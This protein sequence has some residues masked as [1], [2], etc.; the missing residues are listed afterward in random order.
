MST[1][2]KDY[3]SILGVSPSATDSEIKKAY[4]ALVTKWHPD[5]NNNSSESNT[6][7]AEL[8]E[9]YKVLGD[10]KLRS[11]YDSSRWYGSESFDPNFEWDDSILSYMDFTGEKIKSKHQNPIDGKDL[12]T[13]INI[14]FDEAYSGC[15]KVIK[16]QRKVKCAACNGT[17]KAQVMECAECKGTGVKQS[18]L[19]TRVNIPPG[20]FGEK[21]LVVRGKGDEGL[22]GGNNGNLNITVTVE[23]DKFFKVKDGNLHC[24]VHVSFGTACLGGEIDVRTK[25]GISSL[26]VPEGTQSGTI[27]RLK[28]K[29]LPMPNGA[30]YGDLFVE[31]IVDVPKHLTLE[32]RQAMLSIKDI[33]SW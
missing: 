29:G 2:I 27:L 15:I 33:M 10:A 1:G 28:G 26:Y 12:F 32:Q 21:S 25:L 30:S 16:T 3:Y 14:S 6:K 20:T 4:H 23:E 24:S 19:S 11:E 17:G 13:K 31:I 9:A 18:T 7:M 22:F 8:G 5:N